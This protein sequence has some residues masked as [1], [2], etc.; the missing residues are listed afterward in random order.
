MS[1]HAHRLGVLPEEVLRALVDEAA[2]GIFVSTDEG[3]YVEVNASGHRMLGYAPGELVG[4]AIADV[5]PQH[6]RARLGDELSRVL[7]GHIRTLEWTSRRRT[8][9]ASKPK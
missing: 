4:K 7:G 1:T 9:A 5:L 2:D 8:A 3:R 6:E